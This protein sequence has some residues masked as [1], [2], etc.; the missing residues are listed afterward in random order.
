MSCYFQLVLLNKCVAKYK[1]DENGILKKYLND[2]TVY[3]VIVP[4]PCNTGVAYSYMQ[5][6]VDPFTGSFLKNKHKS[7]KT[8]TR[9]SNV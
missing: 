3:L 1:G 5:S 8:Q 4:V 2:S 7:L 9:R 6:T